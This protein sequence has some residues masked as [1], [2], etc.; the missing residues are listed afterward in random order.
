[1]SLHPWVL[2][3]FRDDYGEKEFHYRVL[4]FVCNETTSVLYTTKTDLP[5]WNTVFVETEKHEKYELFMLFS[6]ASSP[7]VSQLN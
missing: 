6:H 3:T 2:H 5:L 1:M 4:T 7:V